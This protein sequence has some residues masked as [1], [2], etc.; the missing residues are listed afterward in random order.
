MNDIST[1][2][3]ETP[4]SWKRELIN[5]I[6]VVLAAMAIAFF[7]NNFVIAN[8]VVPSG[9]M[10]NTIMTGDRVIGFRLSYL[11]SDP[12][13]GD[14]VIFH[15]PDDPTGETYYVKR[16][17]GL[18]GDTVDVRDGHVYLNQADTP[19]LEPYIKEPMEKESSVHFEVP[20]NSYL[21]LGDNRN[22]SSDAREWTNQYVSEDKIIAK[23]LFRYYPTPGLIQ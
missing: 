8:S 23:V 15:F 3:Q 20:E 14:V 21:M 19:L 4:F 22:H 17:I 16:I 11:F 7:L 18:P 10:E 9:S 5:W 12:K 6:F 2:N 13:R 1:S